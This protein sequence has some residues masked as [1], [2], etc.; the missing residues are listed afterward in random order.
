MLFWFKKTL[1]ISN[2]PTVFFKLDF[3]KLYNKVSRHILFETLSRLRMHEIFIKWTE[4]LFG[5]TWAYVYLNGNPC[6]EFKMERGV[7]QGRPLAPYNFLIVGEVLNHII[8]KTMREWSTLVVKLLQGS[9]Q[10]CI[11]Q[12]TKDHSFPIRGEKS[13]M[14]Q[15]ISYKVLPWHQA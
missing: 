6:N 15:S 12:Y 13:F 4:M 11:S 9:K 3:S 8:R 10:Q 5:N 2:Q 14:R 7:K 1:H